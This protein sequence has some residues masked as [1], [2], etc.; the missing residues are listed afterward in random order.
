MKEYFRIDVSAYDADKHFCVVR[1]ASLDHPADNAV[2]F[3][4]MKYAHMAPALETV[5]DCLVFWPEALD[6]PVSI[7]RK[8]AVVLCAEPRTAYCCFFRDQGIRYL[9]PKE[10]V[11]CVDGAYISPKAQL[12]KGVT[13]MPGAYIGGECVVGDGTYIGCGAKL[14]GEIHIGK[15]VVIRENAVLGADGLTTTREPDGTPVTMPQFGRIVIEDDVQIGA[16]AVVQRG[17]IDET[18]ICRRAKVDNSSFVSHNVHIGEN[19][20]LVTESVMLGSSTVGR[21]SLISG[22]A[23][24]RN[25]I[26]VGDNVTVGMGSVVV[27]D[28]PD[29]VVVKGN[30]AK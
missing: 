13:V 24:I 16:N 18:R 28:V 5:K 11:A 3:V 27:K 30:P 1:S 12:G 6:L 7:R 2:M 26:H 8:H 23:I 15:N 17:A 14:T 10:E 22:N 21:N 29:G 9:P 4:M 25:G 19:T 20:M